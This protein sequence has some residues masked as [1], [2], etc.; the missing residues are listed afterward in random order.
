MKFRELFIYKIITS[1]TEDF[2]IKYYVK[3]IYLKQKQN[4][5]I[6]MINQKI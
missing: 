5:F 2:R 6:E 4:L 3:H 1:W